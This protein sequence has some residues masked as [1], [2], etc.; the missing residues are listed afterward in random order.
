VQI[1]RPTHVRISIDL[2]AATDI[3]FLQNYFPGWEAY[4]NGKPV[5]CIVWGDLGM[6]VSAIAGKGVV[7]FRYEKKGVWISALLLHLITMSFLI[8]CGIKFVKSNFRSSS[9]S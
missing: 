5:D 7:D 8:Y 2:S 1:Q 6:K 9:L 3:T 4:Y